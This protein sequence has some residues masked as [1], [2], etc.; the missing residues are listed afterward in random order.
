MRRFVF[1]CCCF[2]P[3][4][5]LASTLSVRVVDPDHR[6]V[7]NAR[8][9]VYSG[10]TSVVLS[11]ASDGSTSFAN[12]DEGSW[13]VQVLAAGFTEANQSVQV[14]NRDS[15]SLTIELSVRKPSE[16]VVVSASASPV[17]GS[18]QHTVPVAPQC[19]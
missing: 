16:T 15:N 14:A 13:R 7:A 18:I 5:L 3:A 8:V 19:P 9:A 1:L 12:L 6:P 17:S 10:T 11:T 2:F 4:A